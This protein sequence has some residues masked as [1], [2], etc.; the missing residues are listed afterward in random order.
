MYPIK[1]QEMCTIIRFLRMYSAL[2]LTHGLALLSI[3]TWT[4]TSHPGSSVYSDENYR[5]ISW[6][7]TRA[8]VRSCLGECLQV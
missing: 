5:I 6:L 2:N 7:R 1:Y 4:I 8:F 3:Q